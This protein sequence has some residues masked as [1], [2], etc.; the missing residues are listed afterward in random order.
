M[1]IL[2]TNM[3]KILFLILFTTNI[4]ASSITVAVSANMSFAINPLIKEF[5]KQNPNIKINT[6]F[7]SSGKLTAQIKH[8]APYD[9]FLS[10]NMKYPEFL[11]KN[12]FCKTPPK[13]YAKGCLVLSSTQKRDFDGIKT[14]L[15]DEV[16]QIAV[17]NPKTAPY[18]I[19]TK[20]ALVN[21]KL[22]DKVSS[23]FVFGESISQ[24]VTYTIRASDIGFIAKSAIYA[25]NMKKYKKNINWIDVDTKYYTPI[26]QG[27]VI[28]KKSNEAKKFYDFMLS[29][30]A[31]NILQKYGYIII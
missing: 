18:G 6:I 15:S 17:A 4:F 28:V 24:T 14:I 2:K 31:K 16:K 22:Y 29:I 30:E 5:E 26:S 27:M 8:G 25:P 12:G 20:E 11:H 1:K 9:I 7:G 3:Q 13:I 10:A 21:A 19:A 23:K